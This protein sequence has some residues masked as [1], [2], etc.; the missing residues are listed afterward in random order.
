MTTFNA[1]EDYYPPAWSAKPTHNYY[2]EVLKNGVE[3]EKK[4]IDQKAMY[5]VGKHKDI[6]DII[7]DNPT[8]SR[9]HALFQSKNNGEMFI[10]DLNSTHGTYVNNIK[11]PSKLFQ[12]LTI[13][14]QI[15]FGQ[16]QRLYLLRC[17][18]LEDEDGNK[19]EIDLI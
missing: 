7:L 19:Q 11:I 10:F 18:K 12:K 5:L 13:F 15:R 8:I 6:C 4:F 17:T 16:S 14:D 3:V 2:L 9:K 1:F